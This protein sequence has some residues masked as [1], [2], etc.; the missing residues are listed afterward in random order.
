MSEWRTKPD[1]QAICYDCGW[2]SYDANA[3][4]NA[5]RHARA[6]RHTVAIRI[7]RTY[8][9]EHG[10]DYVDGAVAQGTVY[11]RMHGDGSA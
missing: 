11:S 7:E 3:H 10:C 9:Y 8:V 5:A 1:V 4:G 2:E 6:H